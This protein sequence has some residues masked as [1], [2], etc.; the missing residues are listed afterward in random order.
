MAGI[1]TTLVEAMLLGMDAVGVEYEKKFV[2]Q[3]NKN[4]HHARKLH[5]NQKLGNPVCIRGD[6]RNLSF[7]HS[8]VNA[9]IFS[10]PFGEANRGSG[11]AKKGYE[12]KYG[13][14]ENLKDRCDRPLS[15]NKNNISNCRYGRTYLGQMFKVY[16]ECFKALKSNKFMVVVVRDVR[17]RGLT[18]P[19]GADTTKL[20]QLAGFE[21]FDIIVNKMY[22]PSFWQLTHAQKAQAKKV[23]MT[24]RTHEYVLVFKKPQL[25]S[26]L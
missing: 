11:I 22:F 15:N 14:D 4:V 19:L 3:A 8:D 23:P 5:P 2:D 7:L 12:G 17:R 21:V 13:K 16:L 10:P 6:A 20:C 9:V 24:L 26:H 1:G 25:N 18:I